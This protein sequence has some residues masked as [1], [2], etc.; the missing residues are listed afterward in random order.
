MPAEN[1][2]LNVEPLANSDSDTFVRTPSVITRE[3]ISRFQRRYRLHFLTSLIILLL[4]LSLTG[5]AIYIFLFPQDIDRPTGSIEALLQ[6]QT[7]LRGQ[8]AILKSAGVD[9][10]GEK[11]EARVGT[12]TVGD[13]LISLD[14]YERALTKR[15][16]LQAKEKLLVASGY[17]LDLD[18]TITKE[19]IDAERQGMNEY[20]SALLQLQKETEDRFN[21]GEVTRTDVAAVQSRVEAAKTQIDFLSQRSETAL[22]AAVIRSKRTNLDTL[23][24]VSTS[25]VRFGG[26]T[27]IL[28]LT[29]ILV[30]IY[31]HNVRLAS[32]YLARAD[33]LILSRDARVD[34]FGQLTNLLTPTI[35]FDKEPR[36]PFEGVSTL[37]KDA[38]KLAKGI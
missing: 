17:F 32:F 14:F 28:F 35:S 21:A 26:V 15:M 22:P 9:L 6:L 5:F 33:S 19:E 31:R 3:H 27:V 30:P 38:G 10:E 7:A 18:S 4:I 13:V 25:L 34:D 37:V 12:R 36:T 24:L 29:S 2:N 16:L 23:A 20:L 1:E 11:A 8:E